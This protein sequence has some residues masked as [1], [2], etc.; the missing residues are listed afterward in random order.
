VKDLIVIAGA[1]GAGKTTISKLLAEKLN[2]FVFDFGILREVH[3]NRE[4][5]NQSE[6]EEQM[7]F[8]NL[9]FII[10]NYTKHGYKNI[11]LNDLRDFRVQQ[12]PKVFPELNYVIFSLFVSDDEELRKRVEGERDSGYGDVEKAIVWNRA[13]AERPAVRNEFKIDNTHNDPNETTAQLLD[14]TS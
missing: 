6:E 13:L 8:E 3:L 1:P 5:S 14:L 2:S 4:W 9:I 10:K 7:S 12:I 11:I